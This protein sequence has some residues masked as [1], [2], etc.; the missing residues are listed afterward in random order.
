MNI[1]FFKI[2]SKDSLAQYKIVDPNWEMMACD[3]SGGERW[4]IVDPIAS[5]QR[6]FL[7]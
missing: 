4:H 3:R 1:I 7:S 2:A 5:K 6:E